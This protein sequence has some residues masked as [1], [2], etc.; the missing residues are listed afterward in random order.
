MRQN[1]IRFQKSLAVSNHKDL[2]QGS[3][4]NSNSIRVH[5]ER[6][7]SI[8]NTLLFTVSQR[9][10]LE[11]CVGQ[12]EF[13]ANLALEFWAGEPDFGTCAKN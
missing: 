9:E 8:S 12:V 3:Q 2:N 11:T 5:G 7:L 10:I 4:P 6:C 13:Y 1:R